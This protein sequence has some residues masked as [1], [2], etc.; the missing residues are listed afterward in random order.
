[1]SFEVEVKYRSADHDRLRRLLIDRGAREDAP[2]EQEDVY[3]SHPSRDFAQTNEAL[4]LR[5][6]GTDNRITYKGPRFPG[7]TKTREEIEISV[8]QG[9]D[10]SR[11]LARLFENLGFRPVAAIRKRRTTFHPARPP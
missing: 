3:L 4:R 10:A 2:V 6:I 9:E 7:P 11:D 5:R 1:M 8:A